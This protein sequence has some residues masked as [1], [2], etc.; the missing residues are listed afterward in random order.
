MQSNLYK[1]IPNLKVF[2]ICLVTAFDRATIEELYV[3]GYDAYNISSAIGS[4]LIYLEL[5]LLMDL[6]K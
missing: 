6:N 4:Q 5:V 1:L 2:L 3:R